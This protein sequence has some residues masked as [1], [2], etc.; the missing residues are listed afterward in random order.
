M[1]NFNKIISIAFGA[2]LAVLIGGCD[3]KEQRATYDG[4]PAR[5]SV[6]TEIDDTVITTRVKTAYTG[7]SDLRGM[8]IKVE[9]RK[10]I[11]MLSGFVNNSSMARHAVDTARGIEGVKSVDDAM[12]IKNDNVSVG[13]K[14]DDSIITAKVK[15]ALLEDARIKSADIAVVT[16]KGQVQLSGYVNNQL[17]IDRAIAISRSINGVH[18]VINEM[19]IKN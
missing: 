11:V 17:Q 7:D 19:T 12:S 9:T 8:G 14:I 6:G 1:N 2:G 3:H 13:N 5:T 10:G 16:R 18:D 4:T 15:S